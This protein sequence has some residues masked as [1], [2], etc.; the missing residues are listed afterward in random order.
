MVDTFSRAGS[1]QAR[2]IVRTCESVNLIPLVYCLSSEGARWMRA[3]RRRSCWRCRGAAG[4][5]RGEGFAG[6][7]SAVQRVPSAAERVPARVVSARVSDAAMGSVRDGPTSTG[8]N[9]VVLGSVVL[10]SY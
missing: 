6:S 8:I 5:G 4:L 2:V 10:H 1:E 3:G 7:L 9:R